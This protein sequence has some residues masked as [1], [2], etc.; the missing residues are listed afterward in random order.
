MFLL[1]VVKGHSID[2]N[3]LLTTNGLSVR[4]AVDLTAFHGFIEVVDVVFENKNETF[5]KELFLQNFA[6]S[7]TRALGLSISEY[8]CCWH[9]I[10]TWL[11]SIWCWHIKSLENHYLV[12]LMFRHLLSWSW[13]RFWVC[14]SVVGCE[15]HWQFSFQ[16]VH[17]RVRWV[18]KENLTSGCGD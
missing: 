1:G 17:W 9:E 16:K 4:P 5:T 3:P 12:D 15:R 10:L 13:I 11:L 7:T 6:R 18:G 8:F 14:S 2:E